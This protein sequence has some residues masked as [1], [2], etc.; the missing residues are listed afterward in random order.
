MLQ[1]HLQAHTACQ[2]S[3]KGKLGG[4]V[5]WVSQEHVYADSIGEAPMQGISNNRG[6]SANFAKCHEM[7][8]TD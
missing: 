2:V 8:D 1:S 4:W 3:G 5:C 7:Q 6:F